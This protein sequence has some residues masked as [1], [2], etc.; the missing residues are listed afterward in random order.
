VFKPLEAV[1]TKEHEKVA[2]KIISLDDWQN[3]FNRVIEKIHE[4]SMQYTSKEIE[5]DILSTLKEVRSAKRGR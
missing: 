4:K 5:S 1:E 3:R 2:I